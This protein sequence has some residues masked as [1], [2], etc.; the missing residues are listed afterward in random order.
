MPNVLWLNGQ[1]CGGDNVSLL[2]ADQPDVISLLKHFDVNFLWHPNLSPEMDKEAIAILDDV[3][4][5]RTP[6]DILIISG[7]V[8][9]GPENTGGYFRFQGK[10]FKDWVKKLS[11]LSQYTLAVGTCASFGGIPSTTNNP[12]DAV[13][14]Q[15]LHSEKGGLLGSDYLS[16]KGMPVINM[17]GCP[18][19][20][21]WMVET[22]MLIISQKISID[23][24]DA[25]NR[26]TVFYSTLAHHGC[27]RNEFYEFKSSALEYGQCGCLFENLGCKGTRC[28]SDCNIRLWLG[29]TGSCTRGGFPCIACTS[30]KFPD[31][32]LP[33]FQTPK[34]GEIPVTLPLGVPKAWYLAISSMGK[35]AVPE[36]LKKKATSFIRGE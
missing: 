36:R 33:Y 21:D 12:T 25:Y 29:R 2:N 28:E 34:L 6:M 19:H 32:F 18:P 3:L 1:S 4:Y 14:M 13:G 23:L 5:E 17:P 10:P 16:K 11:K 27:P 8:P 22:I 20:P 31:E 35:A 7:A 9:L 30:P 15:F 24:L 26:P